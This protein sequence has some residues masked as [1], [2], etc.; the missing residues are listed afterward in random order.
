[1]RGQNSSRSVIDYL[2]FAALALIWSSSFL[3]IKI[4]VVEIP[5]TTLTAAR[6]IIAAVLLLLWLRF[7][8]ERLSSSPSDWGKFLFI[9][10]VGNI[11]PFYLI[12]Y[13]E[14]TIDS[15]MAAILMGIMPIAT[16]LLA[17]L[18]IPDEPFTR[19]KA[20]GVSVGFLGVITLV[21]WDA[22]QSLATTTIAQLAVLGGASCYAVNTVFVRRTTTLSGS[23]MAAGSQLCGSI[24]IVPIALF[25][26]APW[27]LQPSNEALGAIIILGIFP[28][29]VAT[30][31]YFRIVANLGASTMSQVNYVIP[32]LGA[33][34]GVL[35]LAEQLR[36]SALLALLMVLTGLAIV[37][38]ARK[39]L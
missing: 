30:L 10:I 23:V 1:M 3:F 24:I 7:R 11:L 29:A 6:M 26:E 31:I 4:A 18:A 9:G 34:W 13:G 28:T 2:L 39:R 12:S 38:H 19:L 5:P 36:T 8:G 33:G 32:L 37:N 27:L 25:S 17:H 21:G 15:G 35:F 22:L 16:V 14:L 20:L